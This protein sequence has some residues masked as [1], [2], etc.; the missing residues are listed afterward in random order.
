M[1]WR[2]HSDSESGT[3]FTVPAVPLQFLLLA[4]VQ[5][6]QLLLVAIAT[7]TSYLLPQLYCR[8]ADNLQ[9]CVG[10]NFIDPVRSLLCLSIVSVLYNSVN[11]VCF[12]QPESNALR[13]VIFG[14]IGKFPF[15]H[16]CV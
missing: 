5:Q 2:R 14:E 10:G 1:V 3:V 11:G 8:H 16:E 15:C 13:V 6:Q 9:S 12:S 7:I 4:C